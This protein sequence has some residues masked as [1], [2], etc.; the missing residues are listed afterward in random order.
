LEVRGLHTYLHYKNLSL[1]SPVISLT[2]LLV[3]EPSTTPTYRIFFSCSKVKRAKHF[4]NTCFRRG[5]SG[6]D[7]QR[8]DGQLGGLQPFLKAIIRN[9]LLFLRKREEK[10]PQFLMKLVI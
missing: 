5:A 3:E 2:L 10:E 9:K 7:S 6:I 4:T 8:R 1:F